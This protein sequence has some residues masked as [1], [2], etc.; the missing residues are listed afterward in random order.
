MITE[1]INIS[2]ENALIGLK[3]LLLSRL[4]S[5]ET[6]TSF[7]VNIEDFNSWSSVLTPHFPVSKIDFNEL[8]IIT[9][10][11]VPHIRPHYFDRLI[12]SVYPNGGAF[13]HLG[14]VRG[15]G[16]RGFLPSG[17]TALFLLAGENLEDRF[18]IQHLFSPDHWFAKKQ[19]LRLAEPE[20]NEPEMS[21]QLIM[22][23]E[24]VEK[25]T[26]GKITRPSFSSDFPAARIT[27][28]QTWDDLVL[29]KSTLTQIQDILTWL[30]YKEILLDELEMSSKLKPGYRALFYGPPG[31]GKTLTANLLGKYTNRDIYRV[32]LSSVVSKYIGET[33]KNLANLFNRAENKDWILFFDEADALFGRRTQ[34]QNSHDRY[35]NQEVAYLLQR[36]ET[37]QGLII[38]ASNFKSNIDEA[39]IR[40]FQSIIHFPMPRVQERLYL[41]QRAFPDKI[42]LDSE[43]NMRQLAQKFELTGADI[44]NVVQYVCLNA[45]AKERVKV[46]Y[47]DITDGIKR[48]FIKSGKL[49]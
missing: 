40:R 23:R 44:M 9:L 8:V 11:L 26:L 29:P 7:E 35:A 12:Q 47:H 41:W 4:K 32:D 14:G 34:V 21:G 30:R 38:L 33:E 49:N 16:H 46:S 27:T 24:Y 36:I 2:L 39:F 48:E 18:Q 13:P 19:I 20:K 43:I 15:K 37:Y 25:I 1:D 10:A 3:N 5:F 22:D 45:L 31:T 42:Q 28:Q 17:E 6:N